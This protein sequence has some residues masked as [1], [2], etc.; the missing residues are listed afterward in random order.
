MML[1]ALSSS[2]LPMIMT[3]TQVMT[4]TVT[5]ELCSPSLP[6]NKNQGIHDKTTHLISTK[7]TF[8]RVT[9]DNLTTKFFTSR[10]LDKYY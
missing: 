2:C 1:E 6:S 3:S 7:P 5:L 10:F 8:A 9:I 4:R